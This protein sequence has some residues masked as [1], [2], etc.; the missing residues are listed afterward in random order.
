MRQGSLPI[1]ADPPAPSVAITSWLAKHNQASE[2]ANKL[3]EPAIES[4]DRVYLYNKLAEAWA[5]LCRTNDAIRS[6]SAEIVSED[7]Y[8]LSSYWQSER[9][10]LDQLSG[11]VISG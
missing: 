9:L 10:D 6:I 5:A 1:L 7:E 2:I 4:D 8:V 11:P 3:A